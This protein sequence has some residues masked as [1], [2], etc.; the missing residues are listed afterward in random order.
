MAVVAVAASLCDGFLAG[1]E[2]VGLMHTLQVVWL[3][4]WSE[5]RGAGTQGAF[6]KDGQ[7]GL[8]NELRTKINRKNQHKSSETVTE[9]SRNTGKK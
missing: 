8:W 9:N 1:P 3:L 2:V 5:S 6:I 4:L 7:V